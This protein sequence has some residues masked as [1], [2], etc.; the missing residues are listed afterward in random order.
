MT[1]EPQPFAVGNAAKFEVGDRV[2]HLGV[3]GT[4]IARRY[5]DGWRYK[6]KLD[7][8]LGKVDAEQYLI[9]EI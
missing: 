9:G 6:I 8:G 2:E 1:D 5:T 7:D 3:T 4:V